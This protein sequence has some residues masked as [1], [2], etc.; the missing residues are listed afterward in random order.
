M[1]V[2]G[3]VLNFERVKN[4]VSLAIKYYSLLI[5]FGGDAVLCIL[6]Q[7]IQQN[8]NFAYL[9]KLKRVL[10]DN[11]TEAA[12]S[13]VYSS[14]S[15]IWLLRRIVPFFTSDKHGLTAG[16]RSLFFTKN[17]FLMFIYGCEE[18]VLLSAC[19]TA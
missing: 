5:V 19:S 3:I 18:T 13:V 9:F 2:L 10:S 11:P 16:P 14:S 7:F 17:F 1:L 6:L 8:R 12:S 4:V 15:G